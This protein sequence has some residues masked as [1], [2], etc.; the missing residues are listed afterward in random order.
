ML[1]LRVPKIVKKPD[2]KRSIPIAGYRGIFADICTN[3]APEYRS[4]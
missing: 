3:R 1:E 2:M 4:A